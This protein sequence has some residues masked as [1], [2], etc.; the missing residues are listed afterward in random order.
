[1]ADAPAEQK[2]MALIN[3]G[4]AYGQAGRS[5]EAMADYTAA[6][7]MADAP[8]EQKANALINRGVAHGQAGRSEEAIADYTAVIGMADAPA[9]QKA[10][11]LVNRG[12]AYGQ[13]GRSEEEMADY[14]AVIGMAD[15]PAEQ[16]AKAFYNRGITHGQA[17]RS[18]EAMADYTAVIGMADAPAEKRANA[19]V[20]RSWNR[21]RESGDVQGL[22]DDSR[23]ALELTPEDHSARMNFALGL[24]L[25]GETG[26]ATAEYERLLS[27]TEEETVIRAAADDLRIELAKRPGVTGAEKLL[28]LLDAAISKAPHDESGE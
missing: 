26:A 2:A 5:E 4:V 16:K 12:I 13:A 7:G 15:A 25:I 19:L 11:A 28:A 27:Q 1:M 17:G 10:K 18:E 21:F 24:L 23:E 8:A 20:N 6:I 9:E 22:V 14:T 3:R